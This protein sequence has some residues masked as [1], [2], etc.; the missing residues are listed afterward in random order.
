MAHPDRI[1]VLVADDHPVVLRGLQAL[2]EEAGDMEA[3][4]TATDGD[5][6]VSQALA[7]RPRVAVLDVRMPGID[8]LEATRRIRR[9]RPETQVIVLS[10]VEDPGTAVEAFRAGAL[11]FL[12]KDSV[13]DSL[14]T[15]IREAAAGRAVM[16]SQIVTGLVAALREAPEASPLSSREREILSLIAEGR[17][18]EQIS[19]TLRTSV[20][21][22][23]AQLSALFE[24]L[25]ARDRASALATCFRRGWMS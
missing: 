18:N 6:A 9:E 15:A 8:G 20:S 2:I 11:G 4:A 25:G 14:V 16:S 23:K 17:T 12:P 24:K 22:V 3:V 19:R 21:T 10:A 5:G 7:A 1:A 13:G